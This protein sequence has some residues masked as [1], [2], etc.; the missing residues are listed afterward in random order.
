[1]SRERLTERAMKARF[2]DYID[3]YSPAV[4]ICGRTYP[5]STVLKSVDEIAYDHA[6]AA[7]VDD[8]GFDWE[9]DAYYERAA[10]DDEVTHV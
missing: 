9:V 4:T 1:M 5:A 3:E 8:E 6:L 10:D 7:C 2:D